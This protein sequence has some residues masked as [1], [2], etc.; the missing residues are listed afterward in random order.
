MA[1]WR[2]RAR[3]LRRDAYAL[4]F[5]VRDPRVPWYVKALAA[6]VV[7]YVF[8]PIDPV[9]DFI[10]VLGHVDELIVVPVAIG[11]IRR[12]IPDDVMSDCRFRAQALMGKPGSWVGAAV[13]VG[14]W[15]LLAALGVWIA[16]RW[17]HAPA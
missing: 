7:A 4:Y 1:S 5:A 3:E 6:G 10:P 15:L 17:L 2:E 12:M 16:L 11:C 8:S 14:L 9:P 13:V